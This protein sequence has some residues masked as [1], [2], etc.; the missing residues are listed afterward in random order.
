MSNLSG[1][2]GL[3]YGQDSFREHFLRGTGLNYGES[4]HNSPFI[5]EMCRF[6][7]ENH[8]RGINYVTAAVYMASGDVTFFGEQS[9]SV[10]ETGCL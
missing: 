8:E 3:F 1:E 4:R 6:P 7:G 2:T 9:A 10:Q 5:R